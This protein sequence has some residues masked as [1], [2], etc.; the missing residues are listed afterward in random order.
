MYYYTCSNI[1]CRQYYIERKKTYH[2]GKLCNNI[3]TTMIKEKKPILFSIFVFRS[4]CYLDRRSSRFSDST[5]FTG[6]ESVFYSL[7]TSSSVPLADRTDC[8]A[9]E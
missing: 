9:N 6:C 8:P 5:A 1:Y 3:I 7:H 2:D 4:G